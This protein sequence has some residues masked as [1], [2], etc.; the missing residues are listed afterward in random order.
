MLPWL[1]QD[2]ATSPGMNADVARMLQSTAP[3]SLPSPASEESTRQA[4]SEVKISEDAFGKIT[5]RCIK[6]EP[7]VPSKNKTEQVKTL[8]HAIAQQTFI[9]AGGAEVPGSLPDNPVFSQAGYES[10]QTHLLHFARSGGREGKMSGP[11]GP[12]ARHTMLSLSTG[13]LH[14]ARNTAKHE[15]INT[16]I[17]CSHIALKRTSTLRKAAL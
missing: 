1:D 13:H 8:A 9:L 14:F 11:V 16:I 6:P 7:S 4:S 10:T 17:A 2:C 3:P 5:T 15:A 12:L